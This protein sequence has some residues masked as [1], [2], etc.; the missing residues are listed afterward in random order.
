LKLQEVLTKNGCIIRTRLG[1]HE[2]DEKK[3]SECGVIILETLGT[4]AE[5]ASLVAGIKK[6]KGVNV[7]KTAVKC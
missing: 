1:L 4:A 7:T 3:C 6:I 5:T 2:A